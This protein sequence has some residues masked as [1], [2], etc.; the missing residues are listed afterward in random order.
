MIKKIKT[1]KNE[2]DKSRLE[3]C[4]EIAK[5]GIEFSEIYQEV[6]VY[7]NWSD[8]KDPQFRWLK[9]A[10]GRDLK[11]TVICSK[12]IKNDGNNFVGNAETKELYLM[13]DGTFKVFMMKATWSNL[14]DEENRYFREF[15]FDEDISC[16]D[17][18][19]IIENIAKKLEKRLQK[20]G[21]R[22]KAQNARLERVQ[23]LK[24]S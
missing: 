16:F 4:A 5:K 12:H 3:K 7:D 13:E 21:K 19:E 23:K 11:G 1:L 17:Y 22:T 8:Y 24:I 6:I 20:L 15:A 14:L 9:N 18:C 2:I 10:D